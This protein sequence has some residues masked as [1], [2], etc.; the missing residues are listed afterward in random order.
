ME[1]SVYRFIK[2]DLAMSVNKFAKETLAPQSRFST[3]KNRETSVGDLPIGLLV[4]L[5]A[6]SNFSYDQI[7]NKLMKYEIDYET[8]KNGIDLSFLHE[9]NED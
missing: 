6:H 9:Q 3:W 4:D 2:E 7:I 8:E 5:A 1:Y